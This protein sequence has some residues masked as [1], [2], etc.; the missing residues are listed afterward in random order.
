MDDGLGALGLLAECLDV[1]HHVVADVAFE[2][3][4]VLVVD[5]VGVLFHLGDLLVGD[6]EAELFFRL[7]EGDP[8]FAPEAELFVVRKV[9]CHFAA[10]VTAEQGVL[11][12]ARI[13]HGITPCR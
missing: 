12:N 9:F 1:R 4:R 8:K 13:L 7:G 10:R 3:A 2:G 11:V 5:V 6:G